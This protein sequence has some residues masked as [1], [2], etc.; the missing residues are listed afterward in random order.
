MGFGWLFL[1]YM[2]LITPSGFDFMPDVIGFALMVKA[3]SLLREFDK[4]FKVSFFL[5]IIALPLSLFNFIYGAY[6]TIGELLKADVMYLIEPYATI[7]EVVS[8]AL[9]F[10]VTVFM[11]LGMRNVADETGVRM[12]SKKTRR[13]LLISVTVFLFRV[14]VAII[15]L[16]GILSGVTAEGL[17][18]TVPDILVAIGFMAGAVMVILNA[19]QIYSCYMR[20]GLEGE[21]DGEDDGGTMQS[22]FEFFRK[23]KEAKNRKRR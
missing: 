13:N 17:R 18:S 4:N 1:G 7:N 12:I 11:L 6:T 10:A 15:S 2:F 9:I 21:D 19:V 5:S 3:F 14:A 23:R 22:P 8:F 16:T 20:I